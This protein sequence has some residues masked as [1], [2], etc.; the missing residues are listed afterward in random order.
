MSLTDIVSREFARA[1]NFLLTPKE[2]Q[3]ML[4][5]I[6]QY[7]LKDH[8]DNVPEEQK[9]KLYQRLEHHLDQTML[10][11]SSYLDSWSNKLGKLGG[12]GTVLSDAF[13][14][15]EKIPGAI[16]SPLHTLY[17]MGKTAVEA[18]GFLY[19]A[20]KEGDYLGILKWLGMKPFELAI[21]L[22]GP[23]MGTG[24]TERIIRQR[25]MYE[26]KQNFLNEIGKSA[27]APYKALDRRAK[28]RTGYAIAPMYS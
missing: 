2:K 4:K 13:A 15:F 23:L 12:I 1:K 22:L 18:P 27:E 6:T 11:Y 24:W 25:I 17:V 16:Y 21:P 28:E 7:D 20:F 3:D 9:Q 10:K 26:A 14:L 19:Y 5:Y 8:F